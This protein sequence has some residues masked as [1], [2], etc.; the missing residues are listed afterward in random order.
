MTANDIVLHIDRDRVHAGDDEYPPFRMIRETRAMR[1]DTTVDEALDALTHGRDRYRLA[2]VAGG[3]TWALYGGPK[4]NADGAV[5]LAVIA[6]G[7]GQV[8]GADATAPLSGAA[9]R[10]GPGAVPP[11]GHGRERGVPFPLPPQR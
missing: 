4:P 3:A 11:G 7:S 5:A 10:S 8:L 9:G 2:A 1:G 6:E